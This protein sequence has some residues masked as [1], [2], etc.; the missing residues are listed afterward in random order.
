MPELG[1]DTPLDDILR[2]IAELGFEG[3][4][5]GGRF[6]RESAALA[7]LLGGHGLDLI[8]GWY[9]GSLL[10]RDADEEIRALQPPL[11]LLKAL[12]ASAFVFAETSNAVHGERGTPPDAPPQLQAGPR[13]PGGAPLTPP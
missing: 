12:G 13:N 11:S 6:P 8:G 2:E 4:E 5:L 1:G 10:E 3:V 9:S 7:A